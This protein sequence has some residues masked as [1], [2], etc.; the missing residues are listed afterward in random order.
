MRISTNQIYGGA[1]RS[2]ERN[3]SQLV[4]LQN[5]LSTNRRLLSPADDPIAAARA[6]TVRQNREVSAQYGE[7]QQEASARLGL[8][9]VQL[10]AVGDLLQSV[11]SRVV[12]AGNTI[13]ADSDRQAMAAELATRFDE[14]LG[15]ANS[16]NA[17]GEYLF[18]G[19]QGATV[20]FARSAASST[21]AAAT[22]YG[23]DGLRS[24]QVGPSQQMATNVAGSELFMNISDGNGSFS[25]SALG[26]GSG[27]LPNQ[28]TGQIDPGSVLDP[29][30]WRDALAGGFPWQG[31]SNRQLQIQFSLA[32]GTLSYQLFDASTPPPPAAPLTP[33]AVSTVLPFTPGQAI[34]LVTTTQPPATPVST[35]FGAQVVVKGT[36][37]AG[38][39]FAIEPST[40][41]SMFQ[42]VQELVDLLRTPLGS[43]TARSDFIGKLQQHLVNVDQALANVSR[44]QSTVGTRLQQL[45]S[46]LSATTAIDIQYQATLSALEDV[47]YAQAISDFMR[48]QATLEAAKKSFTAISDLSLFNYL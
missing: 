3:Q 13:L 8:V 21:T 4:R 2:I 20:P 39:T 41:K 12:Q 14:L 6:L 36:P 29:Q 33:V 27:S 48:Q 28:G 47:D 11:R 1:A 26:N 22:Y 10:T 44:V 5:Q 30:K 34:P 15:I 35:D 17:D 31:A 24:L 25:T 7:N 38:D 9:D 23:D 32:G 46:L 40:N 18:S 43:S 45:D 19:H 16:R 42:T 37:A